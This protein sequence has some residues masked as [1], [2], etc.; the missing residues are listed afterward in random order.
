M[1]ATIDRSIPRAVAVALLVLAAVGGAAAG[2][3]VI[4][5][6][7]HALGA[8][9]G[10]MPLQPP[11]YLSFTVAGTLAALGGWWLVVRFVRGSARLLRILVPVLLVLSWVPDAVLLATG[12]LPGATPL[13][14]VAL[15]A[16]HVVV[17]A[18]AVLVGRRIAPPR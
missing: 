12:F 15:M 17:A 13:G 3:S 5:L 6:A 8:G 2:A 4:A 9:E 16:M 1:T 7:A 14:V 10:F 18:A 11:A